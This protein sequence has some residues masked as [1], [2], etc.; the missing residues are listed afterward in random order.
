[1][2][3]PVDL[4]DVDEDTVIV[5]DVEAFFEYLETGAA[6]DDYVRRIRRASRIFAEWD[7]HLIAGQDLIARRLNSLAN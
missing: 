4:L 7:G 1:M 3:L 5:G 6:Y 2:T